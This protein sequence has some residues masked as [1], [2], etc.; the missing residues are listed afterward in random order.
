MTLLKL[1]E[2]GRIHPTRIEEMYYLSKAELDEHIK[3]AGEQAVFEA[4]CGEFHEELVKIL[5]RLRYRT[6]YGQNVLKHTLEVV[7]LA[8]IM[9]AEVEASA[10]TAKRAALLHDL[11]KAMTHEV[12]GSHA[13][14]STQLARRY[15]ESPAVCHAIEAHHY[16]VQPQTVEAVLL[17]AADAISASRPGARGESLE[18]YVKRLESLEQLAVQPP[19]CREGLR[20][21]GGP[22][23]P[24]ARQAAGDRR[25]RRGAALARDRA[26]DRAPPGVPGPDQGDGDPREPR[27]RRR[28]QQ[29]R[30]AARGAPRRRL[31]SSSSDRSGAN[32]V[33]PEV[34][35]VHALDPV[36]EQ[37]A[38]LGR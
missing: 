7:Q 11:G 9:A 32:V 31:G 16:E 17:I 30:R 1:I 14:I 5:G 19:G 28:G 13:Q 8:G 27:G 18:H 34:T 33:E 35:R 4:H 25:R 26:R 23:D 10:K 24:R 20:P 2:D 22:R 37:R 15:G 12:E 21:A 36:R 6:S 3:Q 38:P 29:G